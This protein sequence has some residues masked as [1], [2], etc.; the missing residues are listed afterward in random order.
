MLF[1]TIYMYA[2][3]LVLVNGVLATETNTYMYDFTFT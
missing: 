3:A 1:F 2:W